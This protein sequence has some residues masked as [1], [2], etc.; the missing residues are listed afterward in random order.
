MSNKN[1]KYPDSS[2]IY[3]DDYYNQVDLG[4]QINPYDQDKTSLSNFPSYKKFQLGEKNNQPKNNSKFPRFLRGQDTRSN[5]SYSNLDS[6]STT[7]PIRPSK[8]VPSLKAIYGGGNINSISSVFNKDNDE[9]NG[10]RR[11]FRKSMIFFTIHLILF[12]ILNI[13]S[14]SFGFWN[15]FFNLL[16]ITLYVGVTNIFY[17]IVADKS[18]VY[19]AILGQFILIILI[20]SFYGLGFHLITLFFTLI[21]I[22]FS[23]LAYAEL[24]KFQLSSRLFSISHITSESTRILLTT[25]FLVIALSIFNGIKNESS[26]IFVERL[27]FSNEAIFDNFFIENS[28]RLSVNKYVNIVKGTFRLNTNTSAVTYF[29]PTTFKNRPATFRDFLSENYRTDSILNQGQEDEVRNQC[30]SD[31]GSAFESEECSQKVKERE[32]EILDNYRL[33]AFSGLSNRGVNLTLD[34]QLLVEDFRKI[35]KEHYANKIKDFENPEELEDNSVVPEP[36]LIILSIISQDSIIPAVFA[37]MTYLI[38]FIFK[39]IFAWLAFLITWVIW[40]ILKTTGFTQIEVETAE[41]EIVSI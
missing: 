11:V 38:L 40:I 31:T 5:S 37:I 39:F 4:H 22:L 33:V 6:N 3:D 26:S 34:D 29:D 19:L 1:K 20:N 24:E 10:L 15:I 30:V 21:I 32:D 9:V 18:Y 23:Y 2:S 25:A 27:I 12:F 36:L 17:I 16:L 7:E 28:S 41:S 13:I 35:A 8:F 14:W